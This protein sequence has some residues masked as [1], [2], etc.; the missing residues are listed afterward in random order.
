MVVVVAVAEAVKDEAFK[1]N[2]IDPLKKGIA[3]N[4]FLCR[5]SWPPTWSGIGISYAPF[6]NFAREV[7]VVEAHCCSTSYC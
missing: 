6:C 2:K 4:G 5:L 7:W 3:E 1:K